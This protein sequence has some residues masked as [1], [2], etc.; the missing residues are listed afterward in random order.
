MQSQA[1]IARVLS[2]RTKVAALLLRGTTNQFEIA[3]KLG[4]EASQ[5]YTIS[6]DIKAIKEEWRGSAL[7]DFNEA[8]GREI[9]KL[10]ALEKEFWEA[11]DRSRVE[12]VSER[13]KKN[14]KGR[15]LAYED[16]T[17]KELRD[18]NPAFLDGALKC[19]AKRCELLGLDAPKESRVTMTA[20]VYVA[21]G[22]F[23]PDD[24]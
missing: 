7:R 11:W 1:D 14:K 4:M 5:H 15:S 19:I 16:E 3:A 10:E 18:G 6:R 22:E 17:R 2:R 8:R 13:T 20:K 12:K 24:R 9:E 23:D 21:S